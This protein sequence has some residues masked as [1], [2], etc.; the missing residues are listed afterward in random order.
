MICIWAYEDEWKKIENYCWKPIA[1][2]VIKFQFPFFPL[3]WPDVSNVFSGYS[4]VVVKFRCNRKFYAQFIFHFD[5]IELKIFKR[6]CC[7]LPAKSVFEARQLLFVPQK[8]ALSFYYHHCVTMVALSKYFSAI[9]DTHRMD[10]AD[11]LHPNSGCTNFI[12]DNSIPIF[13]GSAQ[14]FF[15]LY[16]VCVAW[17]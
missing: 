12:L 15:P 2:Y 17:T 9:L 7:T 8:C 10:C 1:T 5:H 6:I 16:F 3:F 14:F 13:I 4:L 11:I